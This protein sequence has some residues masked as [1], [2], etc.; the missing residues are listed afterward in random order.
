MQQLL[1]IIAEMLCNSCYLLPSQQRCLDTV[2]TSDHHSRDALQQLLPVTITA[3][4]LCK[5]YQSLQRC[6]ATVVTS[7]RH[8]RDALQQLLPVTI[9]AEMLC[10]SCYQ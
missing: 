1:P 6:F 10:N 9:T 3:E 7:D 2:V 5:S 4:M 8:S